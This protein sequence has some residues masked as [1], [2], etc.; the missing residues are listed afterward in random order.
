MG[1]EIQD[2]EIGMW[3]QEQDPGHLPYMELEI[4]DPYQK[5]KNS[6]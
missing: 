5:R 3:S 6:L 4:N 1:S 2:S